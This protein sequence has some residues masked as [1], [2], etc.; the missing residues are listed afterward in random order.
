MVCNT[1]QRLSPQCAA[2][3]RD[4]LCDRFAVKGIVEMISTVCN[5]YRG[6]KLHTAESKIEMFHLSL[7][8][9]K[10]TIRRNPLSGQHTYHERK[11]L[12]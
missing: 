4:N 2:H 8:A 10:G 9:F 12:K 5:I 3:H 6:D 7:V 1:P 11:Y